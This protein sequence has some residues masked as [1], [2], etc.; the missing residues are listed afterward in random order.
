MSN[1]L[2]QVAIGID[3]AGHHLV[4]VSAVALYSNQYHGKVPSKNRSGQSNSTNTPSVLS[5]K[6]MSDKQVFLIVM[7]NHNWSDIKNN[8]SAP[9]INNTLLP[10][11]SYTEQYYNP[12]GNHPANQIIYG[13]KQAL[14]LAS[15]MMLSKR[16]IIRL[17][18]NTL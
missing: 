8:P 1:Y 4:V 6:T 17:H 16:N 5:T 7:E 2:P 12:P 9:Y 18:R 14:I 3:W 10:I 13:W 11:A 15:A